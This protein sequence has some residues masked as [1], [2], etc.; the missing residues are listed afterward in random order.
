MPRRA[1]LLITVVVLALHWFVLGGMPLGGTDE[2]SAERLAF[3]TRMVTPPPEP[4]PAPLAPPAEPPPAAKP[5][6]KPQPKPKPRAQ[7]TDGEPAIVTQERRRPAPEPTDNGPSEP[8]LTPEEATAPDTSTQ[9][10]QSSESTASAPVGTAESPPAQPVSAASAPLNTASV[11]AHPDDELSAG[12]DIRPPGAAG[13][14]PSTEPPPI[15]LPPSTTLKYAVHGEVK[16]MAYN[17]NGQLVWRNDGGSYEAR[18]EVSAF[19]LGTRSQN[20][21]GKITPNGLAPTRFGD[22]GKREIAAHLDFDSKIVTFSANTNRYT[23]S[24][25]A[26]DRVSVLIQ[27]GAMLAAAPDRYPPGTQISFTTIGPRNADRWT[28]TVGETET[29]DLPTGPTRAVRL[30]KLPRHD[31]DLRAD[32]WLGLDKQYLPVRLRITQSNGDFAELALK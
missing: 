10:A 12:V 22:I 8:D 11:P 16:K 18:Q 30:Q 7:S 19:L 28:F 31:R 26:Q 1:L 15:Q 20:S 13:A 25:G 17:V 4:E 32:L 3:H 24:A 23:I 27:L 2:G 6:P 21:T 5:A 29:L 14:K 9:V